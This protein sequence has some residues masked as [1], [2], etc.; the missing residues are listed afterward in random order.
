MT[1]S[2]E[3]T[4]DYVR[5]YIEDLARE[6]VEADEADVSASESRDDDA[7]H[8][9]ADGSEL[10]IYTAKN[11]P[12]VVACEALGVDTDA[13][14]ADMVGDD[15]PTSFDEVVAAGA[16]AGLRTLLRERVYELRYEASLEED[17]EAAS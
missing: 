13:V 2:T 3:I 16:Y 12:T 6:I 4:R 5:Q 10:V 15:L 8:E 14:L 7:C 9:W 11:L 1:L 17:E